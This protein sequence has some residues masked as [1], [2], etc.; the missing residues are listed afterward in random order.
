MA[1][2]GREKFAVLL[3]E[4]SAEAALR[5]GER[6]RK[7]IENLEPEGLP[8][9]VSIGIGHLSARECECYDHDELLVRADRAV[10]GAK[11]LGKNRVAA[12]G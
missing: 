9:T 7:K 1:R 6:L 12:G 5:V 3:P 11:E 4:A 10:A 8:V 2:Y